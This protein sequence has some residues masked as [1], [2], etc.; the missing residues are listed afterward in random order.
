[1]RLARP[2]AAFLLAITGVIFVACGG[3]AQPSVATTTAV[4]TATT[5]TAAPTTSAGTTTVP[6]VTSTAAGMSVGPAGTWYGIAGLVPPNFPESSDADWLAF[7]AALPGLGGTVG[8]YSQLSDLEKN[9]EV[10][11]AAGLDVLPVTG[12]H[13]D[14]EGGLEV[15]VDF[16]DQQQRD[17]FVQALLAFVAKY[18][19]AYLGIGNEVNRVWEQDPEAY[20]AWIDALPGIVDAVHRVSPSTRV[21]ATFQYEFLRGIDRITGQ[22]RVEDWSPLEA[23][24]PYLDL[25]AFTSYPYFGFETPEDVPDD[26]YA[27]IAEH[28]DRPVGFTELGWPSA[29]ILPL[30]GTSLEGLGGTPSEQAD[31]VHRLGPLLASVEP[32]FVMWVWAYDTP[33]VGPSFESLG[34]STADGTAKPSLAAWKAFV[35]VE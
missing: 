4:P 9:E 25:V 22:Q 3:D 6:E 31:F 32:E 13:R 26:Y 23:A 35:G 27:A 16:S 34:L 18:R 33:A 24:A 11:L 28:T 2:V 15:T 21:F 12:F 14:V 10:G 17:A 20:A 7:F 30:V 1:M 29:P 5:G 8:N 19:P